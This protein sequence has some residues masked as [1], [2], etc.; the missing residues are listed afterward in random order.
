MNEQPT[1]R[2]F[3]RYSGGAQ[4]LIFLLDYNRQWWVI[5]DSG[6][7]AKCEWGYIEQA[8]G[9]WDLVPIQNDSKPQFPDM[10]FSGKDL[11]TCVYEALGAASGCWESMEGTGVFQSE[12]CKDIGD[13]LMKR[14]R[15][16]Q[17]IYG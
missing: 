14:I 7:K 11:E 2:G 1:E 15:E 17:P 12:R 16:A 13:Q 4:I 9:V 5:S 3:Y 10:E 6:E 8:L